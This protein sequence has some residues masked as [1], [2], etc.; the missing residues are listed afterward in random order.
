MNIL[1]EKEISH[2]KSLAGILEGLVNILKYKKLMNN[3][4]DEEK[5]MVSFNLMST[6]YRTHFATLLQNIIKDEEMYISPRNACDLL[7]CIFE[8]ELGKHVSSQ[9]ELAKSK[10]VESL[11]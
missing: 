3:R 5:H 11:S 6:T 2:P 7:R 9:A 8:L 4:K 10:E 1:L